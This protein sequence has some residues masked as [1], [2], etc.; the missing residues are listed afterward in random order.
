[1]PKRLC[2]GAIKRGRLEELTEEGVGVAHGAVSDK[3]ADGALLEAEELDVSA[4]GLPRANAR[5]DEHLRRR[6]GHCLWSGMHVIW[7][8]YLLRTAL[9]E[10]FV[11]GRVDSGRLVRADIRALRNEADSD[12]TAS[13]LHSLAERTAQQDAVNFEMSRTIQLSR[14]LPRAFNVGRRPSHNPQAVDE[15]LR[16]Q[17]LY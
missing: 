11:L 10:R 16:T 13:H 2:S 17:C 9:L 6:I 1:M 4:D 12:S 8:V 3:A 15:S 7:V 5:H 14:G